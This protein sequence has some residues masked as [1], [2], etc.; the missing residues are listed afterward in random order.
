MFILSECE[1]PGRG[2]GYRWMHLKC[3]QTGFCC[4]PKTVRLL[5]SILDPK[6]VEQRKQRRLKRR[7][8][9]AAGPNAVWH[10]D[11]YDKLKPFGICIHGCIDGFSRKIVWLETLHTN[12][13]PRIVTGYY[14]DAVKKSVGCPERVRAVAGTENTFVKQMQ[15]FLRSAHIDGF[16][17]LRRYLQGTSTANQ[18][19]EFF[20]GILRKEAVN[21]W[22]DLFK[23]L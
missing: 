7:A 16:S 15:I 17:G 20:L 5:F 3:I 8:Y 12:N 21:F 1:G 11:G 18:K 10:I 19:I 9:H 2:H 14:I 6:G 13:D 4:I 22:I 23:K